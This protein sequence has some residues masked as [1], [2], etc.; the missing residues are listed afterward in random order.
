[1]FF[2]GDHN[3]GRYCIISISTHRCAQSVLPV[4]A[5]GTMN[6]FADLISLAGVGVGGHVFGLA[7]GTQA[8]RISRRRRL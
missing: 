7:N 5:K 2:H 8:G 1:M 4:L 3:P 6:S